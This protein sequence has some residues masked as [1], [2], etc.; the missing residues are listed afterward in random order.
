MKKKV[1][2]L[3]MVAAMTAGMLAGCGSNAGSSTDN[4]A[5]A[6]N[7]DAANVDATEKSDVADNA[8]DADANTNTDASNIK[9]GMVTDI[10]GVNDGSFNQSSWEGLQRAQSELGVSVDYLQSKADSDYIPNIETFVDED[11]DLIICVGYQLAD[12]LRTEAEANPDQKFAIIDDASNADLDNVTCLMFEQAQASYLVGYVAGLMTESNTIGIVIGMSTDTMNQFGYG[13]LAG[14]IDANPNV[15]VLQTNA[16]SFGDTA[17]GKTAATAMITKGADVI[18]HAAGATG[19]GVIEGCKEANIWAIGVDS[20]QSAL[21]PDNIITSAM[22]RV[23]NAC[24]DVSKEVLEGTLTNG[25]KTYDLTSGGVDIAP[26][27]TNLPEDVISAVEDV[28]AKIISGEI[29]VP[30]TKDDFEAKYGDVYEL[31]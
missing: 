6:T 8:G 21:A 16:N 27:T 15:T 25:V 4:G 22:K 28:K 17:G 13:Y 24:Y 12:A 1:L 9:I 2:S 18:F 3:L 10:G 26:T 19:L 20:D 14:A 30:S 31:D 11:Y 7:S 5:N 23:D 29:T